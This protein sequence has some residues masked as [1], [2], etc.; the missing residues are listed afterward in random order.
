MQYI[1]QPDE[2]SRGIPIDLNGGLC[3]LGGMKKR[4]GKFLLSET[5]LSLTY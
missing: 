3:L 1:L 2:T 4:R 5:F